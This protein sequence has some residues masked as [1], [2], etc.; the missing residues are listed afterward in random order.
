M[1]EYR[2][3]QLCADGLPLETLAAQYGTPLYVYS[4]EVLDISYDNLE[5]AL[6]SLGLPHLICYA[7]KANPNPALGRL[8]A[9]RG[10][11]VDVVSGGELYL[12][13]QMGFPDA[14]IV[15]AG[16][17][18]TRAE[19]EE[20]L[21][22][23]GIRAFHVESRPELEMLSAVAAEMGKVAPVA[24]RVNPDVEAHTHPYI[25][26]G[27]AT[28][29]FGVSPANA[30]AMM[31][32]AAADPYLQPI[33]LHT[34]IG[35]PLADIDPIIEAT[36]RL[37]ELWD[38]L[39]AESITLRTLN[40]GGGLAIPYRPG[41]MPQG[42]AQLAAGLRPLLEGRTLELELEP[43]R[44]LLGPCGVLLTRV[45]YTKPAETPAN[46]PADTHADTHTDTHADTHANAPAHAEAGRPR[47][48]IV[49]DAG[50]NDLIRPALYGAYHPIRPAQEPY[51]DGV[52]VATDIAGPVCESSDFLATDRPLPAEAGEPGTLLVV[53]QV[54]AYGFAMTSQYN[55]RPRVAEVLVD[56]SVARVI[57]PRETYRDLLPHDLPPR[58]LPPRDLPSKGA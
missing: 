49:V 25:T 28:S 13:R 22:G 34:H 54:G 24:V 6:Y 15:F 12:A 42:P 39:A 46:I 38:T 33:G 30:L 45:L 5:N 55:G 52:P 21:S 3:G 29:K 19:M 32:Q 51:A 4:R 1:F 18:K 26:T 43:G 20:A 2:D 47:R 14:R 41:D 27:T 17:G 56:S 58:D 16:V 11:G 8:L 7:L 9:A 50:M 44:Y 35:S 40:I 10:A 23:S 57:R 31:R 37:L 48:L 36:R 53:G